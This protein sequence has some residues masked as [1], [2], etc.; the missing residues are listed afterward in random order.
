MRI[1]AADRRPSDPRYL[2]LLD[3]RRLE[4]HHILMADEELGRVA[5][6][7]VDARGAPSIDRATGHLRTRVLAGRVTILEFQGTG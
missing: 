2:V 5:V 4:E 6:F 1:H 7:E 3:G